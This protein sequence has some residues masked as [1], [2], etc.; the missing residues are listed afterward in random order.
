M[1]LDAQQGAGGMFGG[2]WVIKPS[3]GNGHCGRDG[4]DVTA[5]RGPLY[6]AEDFGDCQVDVVIPAHHD[7]LRIV[8][9]SA[10]VVASRADLAYE[11]LDDLC[12][13]IDELGVL[14]MGGESHVDARMWV[15][16]SWDAASVTVGCVLSTT[17]RAGR[18]ETSDGGG[19]GTATFDA[20][21]LG[22]S[23]DHEPLSRLILDALVDDYDVSER[24]GHTFGWLHKR[25]LGARH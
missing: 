25:R 6:V 10:S 22:P 3:Q 19:L 12:L 13:A 24:D 2:P 1:P 17:S 5:R 8:R 16:F 23:R 15:R 14:V 7:M 20:E 9:L 4:D 21:W 11:D 18:S